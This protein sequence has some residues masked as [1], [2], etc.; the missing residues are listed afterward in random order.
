MTIPFSLQ[1]DKEKLQSITD[2][3]TSE[4]Q[5]RLK[6]ESDLDNSR[7]SLTR[8]QE[9][10]N[11]LKIQLESTETLL[12]EHASNAQAS[13]DQLLALQHQLRTSDQ[14]K[15]MLEERLKDARYVWG[16]SGPN[17]HMMRH[18]NAR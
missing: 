6:L 11:A 1:A 9:A 2:R 15:R 17:A 14:E 18:F 12:S 3:L 16:S 13:R 10:E 5:K 4:E 8:S 7:A